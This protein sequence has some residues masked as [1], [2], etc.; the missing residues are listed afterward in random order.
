M[1]HFKNTIFRKIVTILLYGHYSYQTISLIYFLM[2]VVPVASESLKCILKSNSYIILPQTTLDIL[3]VF[4]VSCFLLIFNLFFQHT[5]TYGGGENNTT[6]VILHLQSSIYSF[7]HLTL[8]ISG[9]HF[10]KAYIF[11][12]PRWSYW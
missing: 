4:L 2:E 8:H 6:E 7:F 1:S 5:F 3:G 11:I 10:S 12:L 9:F